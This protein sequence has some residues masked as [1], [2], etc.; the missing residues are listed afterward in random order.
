MNRFKAIILLTLVISGIAISLMP[1]TAN[2]WPANSNGT[3]TLPVC[4]LSYFNMWDWP[5]SIKQ[6]NAG[7][8]SEEWPS[9]NPETSSYAIVIRSNNDVITDPA[10]STANN[11][12]PSKPIQYWQLIA[13]SNENAGKLV[14]EKNSSGQ[15]Q[16]RSTS[17]YIRTNFMW[18]TPPQIY[19]RDYSAY[20]SEARSYVNGSIPSVGCVEVAKNVVYD[21]SYNGLKFN[22]SLGYYKDGTEHCD[23]MEFSCW[24]NKITDGITNGF[25]AVVSGVAKAMAYLFAPDANKTKASFDDFNSFMLA[26]LGFL[27]YPFQ[28]IGNLF[29]AFTSGTSWCSESSCTKSFGN[30]FGQPFNLNI[31]QLR[32]TMPTLWTWLTAM[33]R[34][35]T[36]L[37]LILAVRKK[38]MGVVHK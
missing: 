38:Y 4:P 7:N 20:V 32:S 16:F 35:L 25:D 12:V 18:D 27:A 37:A 31:I 3:G 24:L 17:G 2:A 21:A 14:I 34:G 5:K 23:L 8:I 26:K 22:E 6:G 29:T 15:Y 28:F 9:F 30:L 19:G 1:K 10:Y 36:I 13:P 11:G 33:I